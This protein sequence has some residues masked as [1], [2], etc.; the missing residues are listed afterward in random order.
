MNAQ[1]HVAL[2]EGV[3]RQKLGITPLPQIIAALDAQIMLAK[4]QEAAKR[5][6]KLAVIGR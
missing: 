5:Q 3:L 2:V 6:P 4:A 1:A